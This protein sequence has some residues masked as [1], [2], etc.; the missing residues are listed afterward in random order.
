MNGTST[1]I[2][3]ALAAQDQTDV[4]NPDAQKKEAEHW[5]LILY[6]LIW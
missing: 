5:Q 2:P 1:W 3:A 6:G 4:R